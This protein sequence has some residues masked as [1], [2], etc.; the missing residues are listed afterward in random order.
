MYALS[1]SIFA[2]DTTSILFC[3]FSSTIILAIPV[4]EAE[5]SIYLVSTPLLF[6]DDIRSFPNES[7][8]IFPSIVTCVPNLP[9]ATA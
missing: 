1:T 5:V 6:I 7:F 2:P 8:P 4:D 9:I 3:P